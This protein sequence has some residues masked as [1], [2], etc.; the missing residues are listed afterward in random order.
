[1]YVERGTKERGRR[2]RKSRIESER[3]RE[4]NSIVPTKYGIRS[5]LVN[6][7]GESATLNLP[8]LVSER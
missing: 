2:E 6:E 3:D 5:R 7:R 1:M 8:Q 4:T